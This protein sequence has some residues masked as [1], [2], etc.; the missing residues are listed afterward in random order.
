[1]M[2]SY[3]QIY[4]RVSPHISKLATS[5][6]IDQE[7]VSGDRDAT[8]QWSYDFSPDNSYVAYHKL[9]R[10]EQLPFAEVNQQTEY[11]YWYYSTLSTNTLTHRT[12]GSDATTRQQFATNGSLDNTV[13]TN[14]R[15]IR[16]AYP[17]FAFAQDLGSV[18]STSVY[19]MFQLSLHQTDAVQFLGEKDVQVVPSLWTSYFSD[20]VAAVSSLLWHQQVQ[21]R[22]IDNH[23]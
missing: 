9:Y 8:A 21:S 20:E 6:T 18:G 15:A 23:R 17:V 12:G 11:G 7:W 5:L 16:N 10:Q 13:D 4:P 14:Y 19:T 2:C 1:M 3:T 22:L